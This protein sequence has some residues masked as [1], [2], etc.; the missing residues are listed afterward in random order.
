MAAEER[1]PTREELLAMAY[2]DGELSG[3]ER[4]AFEAEMAQKSELRLLVTRERRLDALAR[5]AAGPEPMDHEWRALANDPVQRLGLG[6]GWFL[7]LGGFGLALAA[8]FV[9]LWLSDVDLLG[10][11]ALSAFTLGL[12]LFLTLAVRARLRTRAYDPYTEVQR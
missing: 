5:G 11:L 3:P 6:L 10:K 4:E 12:A 1:E 9:A 8:A 2:A 7:F